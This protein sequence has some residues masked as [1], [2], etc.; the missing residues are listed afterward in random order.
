MM[1]Y[2]AGPFRS[3]SPFTVRQNVINAERVGLY[4]AEKFGV[5][6]VIPH[7]MYAAYHGTMDDQFWLDATRELL[8]RCNAAVFIAGYFK[9]SGSLGELETCKSRG[10]TYFSMH[11]RNDGS[12]VFNTAMDLEDFLQ[13]I[14]QTD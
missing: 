5:V 9:S 3:P 8:L 6:P 12:V 10:I 7:S 4:L 13:F 2:V 1:I 11:T 14:G